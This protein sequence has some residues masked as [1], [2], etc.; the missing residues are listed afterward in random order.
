M[1]TKSELVARRMYSGKVTVGQG[2]G[3][4]EHGAKIASVMP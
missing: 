3:A 1:I 4:T 2:V